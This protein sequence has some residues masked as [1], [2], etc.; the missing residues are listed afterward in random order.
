M[1]IYRNISVNFWKDTKV[2]D[3]FSPEDKYFML[4]VLTNTYTNL[5]GCYE[6]SIKQM[7]KDTGYDEETIKKLLNR[8]EA[9]YH[10]I[11]YDYLTNELLIINWHKYNW[12]ASA[13]LDKPLHNE[14]E[15]V[16]SVRFKKLLADLYN[17]RDTVSIRY[18]YGI[19]TLY[20][21]Y[22]YGI[23]H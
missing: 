3:L 7:S 10:V 13:K 19:Y 21:P 23:C 16:K 22:R 4:Y 12:N 15:N 8:L 11:C 18:R 6:V 9:D 20:I 2:M 14:I 17:N 1:A 5:C